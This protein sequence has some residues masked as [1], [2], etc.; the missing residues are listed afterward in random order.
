MCIHLVLSLQHIKVVVTLK[1]DPKVLATETV[2]G[3]V[4]DMIMDTT[5]HSLVRE[6]A[7]VLREH[8]KE[9][10]S[11]PVLRAFHRYLLVNSLP[12]SIQRFVTYIEYLVA[13]G[14]L[15]QTRIR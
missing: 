9:V 1:F 3:P 6:E 5:A 15:L 2:P 13:K 4:T 11:D 8:A 14:G 10:A 7:V 12:L